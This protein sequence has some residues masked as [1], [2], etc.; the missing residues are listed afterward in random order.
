M[1]ALGKEDGWMARNEDQ[2]PTNRGC[3]PRMNGKNP[4]KNGNVGKDQNP[5]LAKPLAGCQGI[6]EKNL[7]EIN[8]PTKMVNEWE[9][10][11]GRTQCA[12]MEE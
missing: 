12:Q 7:K 3:P 11:R 2:G 4:A 9:E 10:P 5:E 1:E 6:E 8:L